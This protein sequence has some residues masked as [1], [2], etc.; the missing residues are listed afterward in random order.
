MLVMTKKKFKFDRIADYQ[1]AGPKMNFLSVFTHALHRCFLTSEYCIC[2]I[3]I[4]VVVKAM[5][6]AN[7]HNISL[8]S[9]LSDV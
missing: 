4:V 9:L 3:L 2:Y 1:I 5:H 6:K 7:M 8:E